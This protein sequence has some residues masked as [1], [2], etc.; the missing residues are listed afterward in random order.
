[1]HPEEMGKRYVAFGMAMQD[2]S[3]SLRKLVD[4]AMECGLRISFTIQ[5]PAPESEPDEPAISD[6]DQKLK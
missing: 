4:L 2:Q 5:A 6:S 1:M 3:T